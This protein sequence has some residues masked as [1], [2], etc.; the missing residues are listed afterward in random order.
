MNIMQTIY[1]FFILHYLILVMIGYIL[2]ILI[3]VVS[4]NNYLY[5]KMH[6]KDFTKANIGPVVNNKNFMKSQC[7]FNSRFL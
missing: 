5:L 3:F 4:Q 7:W 6:F 2:K 1:T